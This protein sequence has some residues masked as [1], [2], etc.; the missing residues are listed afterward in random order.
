MSGGCESFARTD[1]RFAVLAD[2]ECTF[3]VTNEEGEVKEVLHGLS[4]IIWVHDEFEDIDRAGGLKN[5]LDLNTL[6]AA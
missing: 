1:N 6:L 3:S 5:V 2:F 4:K